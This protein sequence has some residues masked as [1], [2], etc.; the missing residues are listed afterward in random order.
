MGGIQVRTPVWLLL[1]ASLYMKTSSSILL[2]WEKENIAWYSTNW[3]F[4]CYYLLHLFHPAL[5][6]LFRFFNLLCSFLFVQFCFILVYL[7]CPDLVLSDLIYNSFFCSGHYVNLSILSSSALF[8]IWS[9]PFCS[10]LFYSIPF[11]LFFSICIF[12]VM[13]GHFVQ[14][15]VDCTGDIVEKFSEGDSMWF[16]VSMNNFMSSDVTD[17]SVLY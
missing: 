4:N 12:S 11:V 7:I 8:L 6:Y 14:G 10:A 1:C 17:T 16:K 9:V 3:I 2:L 13:A 5:H 15:H